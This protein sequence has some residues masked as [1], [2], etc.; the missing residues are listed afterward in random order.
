M[1]ATIRICDMCNSDE[2]LTPADGTYTTDEGKTFDG[3]E[4]HLEECKL[5][6]FTVVMFNKPGDY[7]CH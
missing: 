6:G 7:T 5:Y 1:N 4:A 2:V 3:C